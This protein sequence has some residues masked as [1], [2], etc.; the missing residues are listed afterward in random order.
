[1]WRLVI[2]TNLVHGGE[3]MRRVREA[4]FPELQ[5]GWLRIL[6][7]LDSEGTR[8]KVIAEKAGMSAQA[9]GQMIDDL[10]RSGVVTRTPDAVDKRGVVIQFTSRGRKMLETS[11]RKMA[12]VEAEYA[13]L[14]GKKRY[15]L[16]KELLVELVGAIDAQGDLNPSQR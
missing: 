7:H 2:R 16:L 11:V 4:G 8:P 12:E 6:G 5:A 13:A 3:V 9:T 1:M 10:V 14:V 15:A